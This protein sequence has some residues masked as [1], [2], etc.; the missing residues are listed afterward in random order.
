[1]KLITQRDRILGIAQWWKSN[2]GLPH[3]MQNNGWESYWKI[4]H[5]G[6]D[7]IE[8]TKQQIL[9]ELEKLNL[10]TAAPEDVEAVTGY[11]NLV[12]LFCHECSREVSAVIEMYNDDYTASICRECCE[13]AMVL[14]SNR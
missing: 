8:R 3:V 9:D 10:N 1:M 12:R 11:G 2:Y 4:L 14:W 13:K 5:R 6:E 7:D